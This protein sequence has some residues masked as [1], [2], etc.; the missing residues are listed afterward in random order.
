MSRSGVC[1]SL[2]RGVYVCMHTQTDRQTPARLHFMHACTHVHIP[3]ADNPY[4]F[5]SLTLHTPTPPPPHPPTHSGAATIALVHHGFAAQLKPLLA[6]LRAAAIQAETETEN[7]KETA[8]AAAAP[9]A[10]SSTTTTEEGSGAAALAAAAAA[11]AGGPGA[12]GLKDL[13]DRALLQPAM[14]NMPAVRVGGVE[15]SGV[16]RHCVVAPVL[17]IFGPSISP[18]RNHTTTPL[19]TTTS[20]TTTGGPLPRRQYARDGQGPGH[21]PRCRGG[22][23]P[24]PVAAAAGEMGVCL[25]VLP[26]LFDCWLCLVSRPCL[27][28][29]SICC[30]ARLTY[31]PHATTPIKPPPPLSHHTPPYQSH[32]HH[33]HHHHHYH[34]TRHHTNHNTTAIVTSQALLRGA[35]ATETCPLHGKRRWGLGLQVSEEG[36]SEKCSRGL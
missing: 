19:P 22:R 16:E 9:A 6:D 10:A 36:V 29:L 34:I 26:A 31:G 13:R 15:W 17:F 1:L 11:P 12:G 18:T 27:P 8:A 21:H 25:P 28:L 7:N 20:K 33:H 35:E 23:H 3:T 24:P 2:V 4:L 32:H 14:V 5:P 30:A